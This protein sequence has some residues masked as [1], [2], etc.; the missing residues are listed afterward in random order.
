MTY[1]WMN[2]A[3]DGFMVENLKSRSK[4]EMNVIPVEYRDDYVESFVIPNVERYFKFFEYFMDSEEL[5]TSLLKGEE[6]VVYEYFMNN[7]KLEN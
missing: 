7:F 5:K 2:N 4:S 6:S 1:M 3:K